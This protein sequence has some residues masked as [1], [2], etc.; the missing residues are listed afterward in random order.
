MNVI[1]HNPYKTLGLFGNATEKELQKQIA[2]IN[3]NAA[4]KQVEDAMVNLKS[5]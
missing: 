4:Q 1:R 3:P 2:T 5:K